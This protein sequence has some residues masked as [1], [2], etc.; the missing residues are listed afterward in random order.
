MKELSEEKIY[1]LYVYMDP[2]EPGLWEW[3]GI[4]F[5]HQPFYI[6]KGK[7]RRASTHLYEARGALR[8]EEETT[9][10][11]KRKIIKILKLGLEPFIE[12]FL[13]NLTE[14]EAYELEDKVVA[15]FGRRD[16]GGLLLNYKDGGQADMKYCGESK[17]K[18]SKA[19][20]NRVYT[21]ER[22]A[23]IREANKRSN[24][25]R[26][27]TLKANPKNA[28]H[29]RQNLNKIHESGFQWNRG[30]GGY[31]LNVSEEGHRIRQETGRKNIA[32]MKRRVGEDNNRSRPI[33]EFDKDW[34]LV[35]E[36]ATISECHRETGIAA[37][38]IAR[39][40]KSGKFYKERYFKTTKPYTINTLKELTV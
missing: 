21:P 9:C 37:D 31:T 39:M 3:E 13:I 27:A 7:N 34:N 8:R 1:Y 30:K 38:Q 2:I 40:C 29:S 32:K 4:K 35:R 12:K 18:M 33:Q 36:Y 6:G 11:K 15:H 16:D 28:E 22:R 25:Q 10:R 14:I 23:N 19:T 17:E 20:G 5:E 24:P 26:S